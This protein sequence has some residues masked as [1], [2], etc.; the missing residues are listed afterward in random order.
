MSPQNQPATVTVKSVEAGQAMLA[1]KQAELT[2]ITSNKAVADANFAFQTAQKNDDIKAV[3][4][5]I[6]KLQAQV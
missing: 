5:A 1:V 6:V 4:D 3:Q 2:Q